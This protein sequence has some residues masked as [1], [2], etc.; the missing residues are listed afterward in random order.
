MAKAAST[1][2]QRATTTIE[3]KM[4]NRLQWWRDRLRYNYFVVGAIRLGAAAGGWSIMVL[5]LGRDV[6]LCRIWHYSTSASVLS[7]AQ[8]SIRSA[9]ADHMSKST[10]AIVMK[11]T[12]PLTYAVFSKLLGQYVSLHESW[13]EASAV[14]MQYEAR[15]RQPRAGAG[16]PV[17]GQR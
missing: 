9:A 15:D 16:R 2:G 11:P 13:D 7:S 4:P 12:T 10:Y 3:D 17:R 8:G 6:L 14:I 1:R 5:A